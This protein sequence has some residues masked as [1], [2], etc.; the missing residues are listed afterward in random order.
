LVR[1]IT[2]NPSKWAE[3]LGVKLELKEPVKP[4]VQ[5]I[6]K[7]EMSATAFCYQ[8]FLSKDIDYEY[9]KG[10]KEFERGLKEFQTKYFIS[11]TIVEKLIKEKK[12]KME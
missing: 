5:K 10:K 8:L 3:E 4:V 6:L 11:D 1:E 12:G 9:V 7:T 2:K